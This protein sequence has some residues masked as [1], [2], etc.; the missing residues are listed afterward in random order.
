MSPAPQ[1][2]FDKRCARRRRGWAPKGRGA[3]VSEFF[4]QRDKRYSLIAACNSEGFIDH[5]CSTIVCEDG[6]TVDADEFL[7]YVEHRSVGGS[8]MQRPAQL[9]VQAT[10]PDSPGPPQ[11][12]LSRRSGCAPYWASTWRTKGTQWSSWTMR[13]STPGHTRVCRV[14]TWTGVRHVL[15][16]VTICW[17][18]GA[19]VVGWSVGGGLVCPTLSRPVGWTG[20]RS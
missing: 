2:H 8:A 7:Y 20:C 13:P 3:Y 16:S 19:W 14:C 12:I 10:P 18:V 1:S 9:P 11:T 6:M 4:G 15:P 5:A 17:R